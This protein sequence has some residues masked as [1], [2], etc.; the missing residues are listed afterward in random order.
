M[1]VTR[2]SGAG[3]PGALVETQPSPALLLAGLCIHEKGGDG[4]ECMAYSLAGHTLA[5]DWSSLPLIHMSQALKNRPFGAYEPH[6][7]G[8]TTW[9]VGS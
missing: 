9:H 6:F 2:D 8:P 1:N 7:F 4:V 3:P 5:S